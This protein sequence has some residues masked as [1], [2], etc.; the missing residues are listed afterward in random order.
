[1]VPPTH[2]RYC[3]DDEFGDVYSD[4]DGDYADH[5]ASSKKSSPYVVQNYWPMYKLYMVFSR[6]Y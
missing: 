2:R 1:M 5:A 4:D 6:P 3:R